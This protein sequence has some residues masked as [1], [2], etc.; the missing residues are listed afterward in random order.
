MPRPEVTYQSPGNGRTA[1]SADWHWIDYAAIL[2]DRIWITIIVFLL[3]V[4]IGLYRTWKETPLYRSSA[5]ILIEEN[6][7]KLL[8][9]EDALVANVRNLQQFNT[10]V[11]ALNSRSMAEAAMVRQGLDR[12]PR[13]LSTNGLLSA[14]ASAALQFVQVT[15]VPQ[16]RLIDIVVEHPDPG[17][18][19]AFANGLA[20]QYIEMNLQRRSDVTTESFDW[21]KQQ[22]DQYRA[23]IEKGYAAIHDYRETLN[24][25]SLEENENLV[26][27]KLK[28]ISA[29]LQD[30]DSQLGVIEAEWKE[31]EAARAAG[32]PLNTLASVSR[33]EAVRNTHAA[34]IRQQG[35]VQ[36]L[37]NRYKTKHPAL[38]AAID[39]QN[40]LTSQHEAACREAVQQMESRRNI[41]MGRVKSLRESLE[42]QGKLAMELDRKL[43][44]YKELKR[45]VEADS[46]MYDVIAARMKET[47]F[48]GDVKASNI[49]FVD[50]AEAALTPFSP[51]WTKTILNCVLL[52]LFLGISLSYASYFMDDRMKRVEDVEHKLG[53]PVLTVVPPVTMR[54]AS[55]RSRVV[56]KQPFCP[57]SEA[58]RSLRASLALRPEWAGCRRLMIT[59][60][61]AG[62]GKST[63]AANLAIVLAQSGQRTLL[64]DADMRRPTLQKTFGLGSVAGLADAL[65]GNVPVDAAVSSMDL[66]N[67]S[68]MVAGD[69]PSNPSELL[70][71]PAM[72]RL[73]DT[74]EG[75]FDRIVIDCPP[76]FGV[77]DPISLLPA[78]NCV[79]FVLHYGKTGSRAAVRAMSKIR[80]G[81][82]SF[83]GLV[84][85][86][87]VLKLSSGYYYYYQYHKYG[88]DS[89]RGSGRK[90]R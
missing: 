66:P 10:H 85:N 76:V 29:E 37:Q 52:G 19:A 31:V 84:F 68:V 36:M 24:V 42:A 78:V 15:P 53:M 18:A 20:E 32:R 21:L 30:A 75:R 14:R 55:D 82:A 28:S 89:S 6:L 4:G 80:E 39:L 40:D 70:A 83:V 7:P 72:R 79:I 45:E 86:N 48:V 47:K 17:M 50:R 34:L 8:N 87:V 51:V 12:E 43:V 61:T 65:T 54:L 33:E 73:L 69:I 1:P 56:E 38:T 11:L 77:S 74:L 26:V 44:K 5:R 41:A 2:L 81:G 57:S 64:I 9:I 63:V 71:S 59:S 13:F 67:L 88:M 25:V 16:S 46:K 22:A 90:E 23:K 3:V 27:G 62:E 49:R 35:E 58:F 60:T